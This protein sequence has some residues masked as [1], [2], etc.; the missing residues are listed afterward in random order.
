MLLRKP[1][2][3]TRL[4]ILVPIPSCPAFVRSPPSIFNVDIALSKPN[5]LKPPNKSFIIGKDFNRVNSFPN[6]KI[7]LAKFL[8]T[9]SVISFNKLPLLTPLVVFFSSLSTVVSAT[10]TLFCVSFVSYIL[11]CSFNNIFKLCFCQNSFAS[12]LTYY[13]L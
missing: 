5:A 8:D 2:I 1:F 3:S 11:Y 9:S 10:A 7:V 4:P 12:L 13:H 6:L